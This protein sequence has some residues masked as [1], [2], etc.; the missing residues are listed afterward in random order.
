M[1]SAGHDPIGRLLIKAM[2]L[3]RGCIH[4]RLEAL[5]LYRGQAGILHVLWAE[6]GIA[7]S[8]IAARTWVSPATITNALQRMEQIGLVERRPDPEDQRCSRVYLTET[9]RALEGPVEQALTDVEDATLEGFS[10]DERMLLRQFLLRMIDNM[11][12]DV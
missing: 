10:Q 6:E 8:E 3:H 9:G 1:L 2:K 11:E 7:Q 12:A 4:D 5:G